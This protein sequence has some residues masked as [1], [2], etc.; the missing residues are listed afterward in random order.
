MAPSK[1]SKIIKRKQQPTVLEFVAVAQAIGLEP[2]RLFSDGEVIMELR[3]LRSALTAADDLKRQLAAY[4]PEASADVVRAVPK[5]EAKRYA[6]PV[7]A[8]ASSNVE[9]FPEVETARQRIPRRAWNRGARMTARAIGDSMTGPNGIANGELVFVKPTTNRRAANGRIVVV[10][11]GDAV[12][13]KTLEIIGRKVRL[14]S[15]NP[16][17]EPIE[18]EEGAAVRL[19]GIAIDHTSLA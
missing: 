1:L 10:T 8:A 7:R 17:H 19:V 18:P 15:I 3:A 12:Y 13:L 2:G 5:R 4:L 14:V 11:V 9:L 6:R 16:E